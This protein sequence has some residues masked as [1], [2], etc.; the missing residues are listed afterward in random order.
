VTASA[1]D[2]GY[3]P[4]T[5]EELED[6]VLFGATWRAIEITDERAIV[7]LCQCTGELVERRETAD[8]GMIEYLRMHSPEGDR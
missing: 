7:E 6:W 8:A 1:P 2:P 3:G 4:V 5:I